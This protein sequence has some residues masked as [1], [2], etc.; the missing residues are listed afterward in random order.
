MFSHSDGDQIKTPLSNFSKSDIKKLRTKYLTFT[1][2]YSSL[3]IPHP[4]ME[5]VF[6]KTLLDNHLSALRLMDKKHASLLTASE[7]LKIF[8]DPM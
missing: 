7:K 6:K 8:E 3:K 4:H 1:T 2:R 5:D